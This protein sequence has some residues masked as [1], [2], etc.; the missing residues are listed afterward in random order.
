[1]RSALQGVIVAQGGIFARQQALSHGFS[2]RE[3]NMRTRPGGSW[4]RVR[5]GV[6]TPR[7]LRAA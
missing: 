6:Y 3:F 4:I 2:P 7:D 5:Y 1:M